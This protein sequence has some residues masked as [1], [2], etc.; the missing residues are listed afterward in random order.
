MRLFYAALVGLILAVGFRQKLDGVVLLFTVIA[1][2]CLMMDH[3]LETLAL[4]KQ[5][6]KDLGFFK[7]EE[8]PQD[9]LDRQKYE[10]YTHHFDKEVRYDLPSQE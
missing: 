3:Y 1:A 4:T 5:K 9:I 7:Y 6:S 10:T 2:V 8:E